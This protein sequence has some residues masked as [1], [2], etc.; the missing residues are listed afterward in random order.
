MS[1]LQEGGGETVSVTFGEHTATERKGGSALLVFLLSLCPG[2]SL[3][4]GDHTQGADAKQ[5]MSLSTARPWASAPW[6]RSCHVNVFLG[7]KHLPPPSGLTDT[8]PRRNKSVWHSNCPAEFFSYLGMQ[9]AIPI[10]IPTLWPGG[11]TTHPL[12]SCEGSWHG[13]LHSAHLKSH[14]W[15]PGGQWRLC[16]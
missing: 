10:S 8:S 12:R 16:L 13:P 3:L 5:A 7:D 15:E 4:L 9:P 14:H 2:C 1:C 11:R 6:H